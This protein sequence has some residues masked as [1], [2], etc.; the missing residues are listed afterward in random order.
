MEGY[1]CSQAGAKPAFFTHN[2]IIMIIYKFALYTLLLSYNPCDVFTYYNV[3]EMHGLNLKDCQAYNNTSQDAYFAGWSNY[4]PNSK[5]YK[6]DDAKF[7]FINLN[8][9]NSDVETFALVMHE[10]MHQSFDIHKNKINKEEEIITW[11]EKEAHVVIKIINL[12]KW[13]Q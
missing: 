7:V 11:A 10:L 8:R 6:K 9:C 12:N 3:T 13:K 4:I 2:L 1:R 5:G